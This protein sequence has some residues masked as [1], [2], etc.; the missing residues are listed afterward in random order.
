[1][2]Q[3]K[4]TFWKRVA[5]IAT[6]LTAGITVLMWLQIGPVGSKPNPSETSDSFPAVSAAP[7]GD[8]TATSGETRGAKFACLEG[9]EGVPC[10][11]A[12][13]AEMVEMEACSSE[14][15]I[16]FMGG[17]PQ[18]DILRKSLMV[19]ESDDGCLVEGIDGGTRGSLE[20]IFKS[21]AGDVYRS[22]WDDVTDQ[23]IGCDI[24]HFAERIYH[25]NDSEVSCEQNFATF[26][27]RPF[28][29]YSSKL[30]LEEQAAAGLTS[31]WVTTRSKNLLC[32]S[33]RNLG[34]REIRFEDLTGSG[35]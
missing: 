31:C 28:Q 4:G 35:C 18:T 6:V 24:P 27:G 13:T 26:T 5:Q 34:D 32:G 16:G 2:A 29:Q 22:C 23:E 7:P 8:V 19:S 33:V 3:S 11:Q 10:N 21:A 30:G 25:G 20:N 1:M 15:L 12:H 14:A 9:S 17:S